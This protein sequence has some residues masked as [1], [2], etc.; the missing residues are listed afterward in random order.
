M[1]INAHLKQIHSLCFHN[2]HPNVLFSEFNIIFYSTFKHVSWNLG[3]SEDK[4]V[5]I[6]K[7][8]LNDDSPKFG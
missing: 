4:T 6:W 2:R 1:R 7:I 3:G 5:Q 8:E